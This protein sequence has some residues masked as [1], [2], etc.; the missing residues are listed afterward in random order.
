MSDPF[1]AFAGFEKTEFEGRAGWRGGAGPAVI[2]IHEMPGLHPGVV[3]F[4]RR[5]VDAGFTAYLP[6]L[7]GEPGRSS[8]GNPD[9][10]PKTAHSVLTEHLVD[11]PGH[12]TRQALDRVLAFYRDRLHT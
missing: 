8:P 11:A 10:I 4:G 7:F 12:P 5:L 6:S 9:G 1:D 3:D 2:A